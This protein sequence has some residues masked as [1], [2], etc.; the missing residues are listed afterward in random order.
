MAATVVTASSSAEPEAD[1][2]LSLSTVSFLERLRL[3]D[4]TKKRAVDHNPPPKGKRR[5]HGEQRTD[6]EH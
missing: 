1:V 4:L 6:H 3:S 5:C 2:S